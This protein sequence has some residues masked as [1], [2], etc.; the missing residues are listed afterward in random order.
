MSSIVNNCTFVLIFTLHFKHFLLQELHLGQSRRLGHN[1]SQILNPVN[2]LDWHQA[3]ETRFWDRIGNF[4][5]IISYYIKCIYTYIYITCTP[6]WRP[7]G[8]PLGSRHFPVGGD[9][10]P[11]MV[12]IMIIL[13]IT[14]MIIR[15]I[16]IMISMI[17][18]IG[19]GS[20]IL[21]SS[22]MLFRCGLFT[23]WW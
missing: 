4:F 11:G 23:W 1:C 9:W 8:C 7:S 14:I 2:G 19:T 15:M 10:G 22:G 20:Q 16:T 12:K 3:L 5:S 6:T 18:M 21:Y 13:S 17:M